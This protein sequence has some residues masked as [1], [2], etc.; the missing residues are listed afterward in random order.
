MILKHKKT[1]NWHS[2]NSIGKN[3]KKSKL[4]LTKKNNYSKKKNN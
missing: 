4:N 3:S 2:K 1:N